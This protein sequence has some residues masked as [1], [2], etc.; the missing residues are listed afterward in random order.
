VRFGRWDD[1]LAL[2]RPADDLPYTLAMWHHARGL[3]LAAKGRVADAE[4]S[5]AEIRRL[6]AMVPA[7]RIVADNQPAALHLEV[8][9]KVLAGDLAARRK[10]TDDAV[11]LLTEAVAAEDRMPY[12]EPP[13]WY[14]PV[15]H[16]LGAVL[17]SDGRVTE[18]E[19]VYREDLRRNP[20]NGWALTGLR[21]ALRRGG[22]RD[23]A[24]AVEERRY[25]ALARA[26]VKLTASVL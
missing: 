26:D 7:D 16:R 12:M 4:A 22:K 3:A 13:P 17:L 23:E 8:A 14:Q 18:A 2:P 25:R 9:E 11:R 20:E 15:R 1:V 10:R 24:A 6:A 19:A 21:E 5:L